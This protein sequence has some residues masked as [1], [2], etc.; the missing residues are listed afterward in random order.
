M[1]GYNSTYSHDYLI[2]GIEPDGRIADRVTLRIDQN[3]KQIDIIQKKT[4]KNLV[5]DI[6]LTDWV[7]RDETGNLNL[8]VQN[9]VI[10]FNC[11]RPNVMP[12]E[13]ENSIEA[14]LNIYDGSIFYPQPQYL[15]LT[16]DYLFIGT[17]IDDPELEYTLKAVMVKSSQINWSLVGEGYYM[18]QCSP[19]TI[20]KT[21]VWESGSIRMRYAGFNGNEVS[22]LIAVQ[23]VPT[24]TLLQLKNI[25]L[26]MDQPIHYTTFETEYKNS[27]RIQTNNKNILSFDK[28][29][30]NRILADNVSAREEWAFANQFF[31]YTTAYILASTNWQ[32]IEDQKLTTLRTFIQDKYNAFY[33]KN[34]KR[35]TFGLVNFMDYQMLY[36]YTQLLISELRLKCYLLGYE[37]NLKLD[38]YQIEALEYDQ[39][40]QEV[41]YQ[42]YHEGMAVQY[43]GLP[44]IHNGEYRAPILDLDTIPSVQ[45]A[46]TNTAG[47]TIILTFNIPMSASFVADIL[48]AFVV[49]SENTVTKVE[50]GTDTSQILIAVTPNILEQNECLLNYNMTYPIYSLYGVLVQNGFD[51]LT[52]TNNSLAHS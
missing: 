47:N 17:V 16:F 24:Y 6:A 4:F 43:L 3:S 36:P 20:N 28:Y 7:G 8:E 23:G 9:D 52:V 12:E 29:Y 22:L 37:W 48:L 30:G 10:M 27:I 13:H 32:S 44:V 11:Q 50:R 34:K 15:T 51:D 49:S 21:G 1:N 31:C 41:D 33:L 42:V 38:T 25:S 2:T 14:F 5:G 40:L 19:I 39:Y 26:I 46:E 45:S 18:Q 35:V